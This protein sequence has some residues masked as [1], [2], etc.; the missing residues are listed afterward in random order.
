[1]GA[2]LRAV[3]GAT[4]LDADSEIEVQRRVGAL[5]TA[6]LAR[7]SLGPGDLVSVVFTVTEDV[8]SIYPASAARALP[9]L[10]DVPM[11]DCREMAVAGAVP[12]CIR[13]LV[14]CFTE[15]DRAEIQH[16]YL[17]GAESLRPDLSG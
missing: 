3:R 1:M 13:V 12:R 15:R 11:L 7:N 5:L 2:V 6:I 17:E 8:T 9:G 14:H 10:S 16:V 4:T